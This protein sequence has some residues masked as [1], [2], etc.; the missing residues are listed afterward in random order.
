MKTNFKIRKNSFK[1]QFKI[2]S[3]QL[4]SSDFAQNV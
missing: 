2:A 4:F 1:N 3:K